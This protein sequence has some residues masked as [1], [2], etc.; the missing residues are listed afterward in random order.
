MSNSSPFPHHPAQ[1]LAAQKAAERRVDE[2]A[3]ENKEIF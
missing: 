2:D 3:G 1:C